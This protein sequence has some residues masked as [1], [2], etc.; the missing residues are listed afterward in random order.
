L[1]QELE[2]L[3]Q[4]EKDRQRDVLLIKPS[5]TPLHINQKMNNQPDDRNRLEAEKRYLLEEIERYRQLLEQQN[6]SKELSVDYEV[7]SKCS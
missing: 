6:T 1:R 2:A 5:F 4:I 3:K 7:C